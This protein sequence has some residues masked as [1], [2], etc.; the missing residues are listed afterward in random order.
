[1]SCS[2]AFLN[3]TDSQNA[4]INVYNRRILSAKTNEEKDAIR[5]EKRK[6]ENDIDEEHDIQMFLKEISGFDEFA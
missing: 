4:K 2:V 1:M 3:R 6:Y 5:S